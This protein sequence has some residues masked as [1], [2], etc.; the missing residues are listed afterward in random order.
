MRTKDQ[1]FFVSR[2]TPRERHSQRLPPE[3]LD[4]LSYSRGLGAML[5]PRCPL[6]LELHWR[7]NPKSSCSCSK[8]QSASSF[9]MR[10]ES[11]SGR[12]VPLSGGLTSRRADRG[13]NGVRSGADR[14]AA[15]LHGGGTG[16]ASGSDRR[17]RAVDVRGLCQSRRRSGVLDAGGRFARD[18]DRTVAGAGG[19]CG[20]GA[21]LAVR[22]RTRRGASVV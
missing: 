6:P 10:L 20:A 22:V 13:V 1:W 3:A 2:M 16:R 19:W 8:A 7:V 11:Q 9:G 17:G 15:R 4:A 18:G 12:L 14:D 5:S 21:D